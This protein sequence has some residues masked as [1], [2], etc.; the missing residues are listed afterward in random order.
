MR[1]DYAKT[2]R[3]FIKGRRSR[4]AASLE[5]VDGLLIG[6]GWRAGGVDGHVGHLGSGMGVAGWASQ[7]AARP[8]DAVAEEALAHSGDCWA[9]SHKNELTF[10]D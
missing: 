5:Q 10:Q 4:L 7:E 6:N 8:F 2:L 3:K 1:K 9:E